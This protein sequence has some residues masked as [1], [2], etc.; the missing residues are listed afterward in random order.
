MTLATFLSRSQTVVKDNSPS[1]LA[2]LAVGGV[3][4]T[5]LMAYSAGRHYQHELDLY[6]EEL[7]AKQKFEI[8][9]RRV[10]MV[11]IVGGITVTC[12]V[13][14]TAINNRRNAALAGLVTLG[15]ISFREYKDKVEKIVTKDKVEKI[16]Q[17]VAQEKLDKA[18]DKE[19]IYVGEGDILLFDTLTSRTFRSSKLAIERA[20]VEMG[21][22]ILH[23]D[24]VS[25]NQ[26]YTE[27][28]LPR[29]SMG[30]DTGWNHEFPLEVKFVALER[31]D[32]PVLGID[33]RF[34]PST[35]FN[36][37]S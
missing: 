35:S 9:W 23:D 5:G 36:R 32:K 37:Y 18:D 7:P 34:Q 11:S 31:D 16:D 26:W 24:Y 3:A 13:A 2:A 17:A 19:V 25:Q 1:I 27:I 30:D 28:G 20:E 29:V 21:R 4:T 12:I 8:G 6:D 14:S 10:V 33:Y 15:E 22:R